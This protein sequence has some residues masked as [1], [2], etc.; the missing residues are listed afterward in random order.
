MEKINLDMAKGLLPTP[1]LPQQAHQVELTENAR[2]VLI[3]RYVR[4]GE[5]GK[6]AESI[7]EMFWRVAFHVA[8]VEENWNGDFLDRAQAFYDLLTSK[9]FFPNSQVGS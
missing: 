6:P 3:R 5:T 4:R 9:R 2:Q 1:P 8:R 7:E